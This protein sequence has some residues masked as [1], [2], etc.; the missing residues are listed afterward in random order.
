MQ[1]MQIFI[2]TLKTL[3]IKITYKEGLKKM[4]I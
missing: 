1:M 4:K 3:Q 2:V